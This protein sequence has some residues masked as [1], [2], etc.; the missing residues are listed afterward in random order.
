ME[1]DILPYDSYIF[2]SE[3]IYANVVADLVGERKESTSGNNLIW[4]CHL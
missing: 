1:F 3:F 2:D 4:D